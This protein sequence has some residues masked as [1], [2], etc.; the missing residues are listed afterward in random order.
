M[1]DICEII[2]SLVPVRV[3]VV[4]GT[5]A[6]AFGALTGYFFG[7]WDKALEALLILMVLDYISGMLAAFIN[8]KLSLNSQKGFKGIARKLYI[9]I[10]VALAHFADSAL[11][12]KEICTMA[13]FFY[14][15][16][17][18][19]SIIENAAKAGVPIPKSLKDSLEQL[20][21]QKKRRAKTQ[22]TVKK[23]AAH[24]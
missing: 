9:L 21:Q 10:L 15:A 20:S 7:E 14:I 3:E 1:N 23:G 18:G 12:T 5:A 19:L 11:G 4:W 22:G 2:K 17:E 8:P 13:T 16:N 6:G 24:G